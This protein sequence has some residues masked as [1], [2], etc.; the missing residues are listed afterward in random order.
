MHPSSNSLRIHR[1]L[2][3]MR[4][5][6][7]IRALAASRRCGRDTVCGLLVD[8]EGKVASEVAVG[9]YAVMER[10]GARRSEK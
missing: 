5:S 9:A 7:R 1:P 3:I 4:P 6:T 2:I 10:A 8:A